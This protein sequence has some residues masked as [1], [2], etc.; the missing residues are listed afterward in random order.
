MHG[1]M[2][3][4]ALKKLLRQKKLTIIADQENDLAKR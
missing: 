3:I 2:N 1:Y 4:E